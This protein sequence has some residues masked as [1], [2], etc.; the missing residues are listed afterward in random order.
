MSDV[1]KEQRKFNRIVKKLEDAEF[2]P[3][4]KQKL[5]AWKSELYDSE[6]SLAR[7]N[8]L[9][10]CFRLLEQD[11][12]FNILNPSKAELRQLVGKIN[13]DNI[14]ERSLSHE[15]R[16][17]YKKS[18]K[19]FYKYL[20]G[21]ENPELI[22]FITNG[23]KKGS[24]GVNPAEL[25]TANDVEKVRNA[26]QNDRDRAFI[27]L[28]WD[29]GM[30]PIEILNVKWKHIDHGDDL[31]TVYINRSKTFKRTL[32]FKAAQPYL[33][34][35][36]NDTSKDKPEDYVFIKETDGKQASYHTMYRQLRKAVKRADLDVPTGLKQYRKG[37][38]TDF[39]RRG[40]NVFELMEHFGWEKPETALYYIKLAKS[41]VFNA[42]KR[43]QSE[44]RHNTA[45][46]AA[47]I[48]N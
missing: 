10:N 41:D 8:K 34:G 46:K 1:F 7:V 22:D 38:A 5:L 16:R 48:A 18:I 23:S 19:K 42:Y 33:M 13:R 40:Y 2:S 21:D 47:I 45:Q 12:D 3:K 36:K 32:P 27:T 26:F 25:P 39:A 9:L 29:T 30:R 43:T 37:R 14:R 4:E 28:L 35:W 44:T 11:I 17:D 6:L 31:S 24:K 15:T 20:E